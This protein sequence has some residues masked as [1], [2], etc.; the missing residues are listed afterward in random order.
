MPYKQSPFP[1]IQG[2]Q[3]HKEAVA[4]PNK[5]KLD[6]VMKTVGNRT[7]IFNQAATSQLSKKTGNIQVP[8]HIVGQGFKKFAKSD[9]KVDA[10]SNIKVD[11]SK[12]WKGKYPD[13]KPTQKNTEQASKYPGVNPTQKPHSLIA[14]NLKKYNRITARRDAK[15]KTTMSQRQMG[16]LRKS[17]MTNEQAYDYVQGR[18]A[19]YVQAGTDLLVAAASGGR[20]GGGSYTAPSLPPMNESQRT[21]LGGIY[22]QKNTMASAS[23]KLKGAGEEE[24]NYTTS[25]PTPNA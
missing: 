23:S 15:G 17:Q 2:S 13:A 25:P 16:A 9:I 12:G 4:S 21:N 19:M 1:M 24:E 7:D 3:Q 14:R 11:A 6:K 18:N 20:G 10:K 5:V 22:Q 8:E